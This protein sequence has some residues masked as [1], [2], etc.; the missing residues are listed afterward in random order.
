MPSPAERGLKAKEVALLGIFLGY[1]LVISLIERM[2]PLGFSIPGIRLG[3]ANVAVLL[4]LYLFPLSK[5]LLLLVLKC[6][7]AAIFSGSPAALFYSLG[8]S[9]LSFVV[10]MALIRLSREHI[11]PIGVSVVG[12]AFHNLG[13]ILVACLLLQSWAVLLY[14]PLLLLIGIGTGALIGILVDRLRP[15]LVAYLGAGKVS[16]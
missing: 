3:L 16:I 10:M 2:I 9:L 4:A 13:Q 6:L 1:T 7:L 8:G 11:S 12:A 15:Y 5:A 14:L